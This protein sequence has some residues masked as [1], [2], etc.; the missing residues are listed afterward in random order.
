MQAAWQE[1]VFSSTNQRQ[2]TAFRFV[3]HTKIE[4]YAS[5]AFV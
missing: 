2:L 5:R 4:L 1:S 3:L